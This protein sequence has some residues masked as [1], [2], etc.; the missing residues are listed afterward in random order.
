MPEALKI[1]LLG[2][3]MTA[4]EEN[5]I[6]VNE[7][8][9]DAKFFSEDDAP[10]DGYKWPKY[11]RTFMVCVDSFENGLARGS[12]HNYYYRGADEFRSLDQL[13]FLM[14]EVMESA[15]TPMRDSRFRKL[16]GKWKKREKRAVDDLYDCYPARIS[17]PYYT[18]DSI[19]IKKG[20]LA[21]FYIYPMY[22]SHASLQG[23]L[24]Q[25]GKGG[26]Q[27]LFRSEME[28]LF[29]LREALT[30]AENKE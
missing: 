5:R 12:L 29:L 30:T 14:E 18:P 27:I 16:E 11:T 13:L 2:K 26:K 23:V 4:M 19:Q 7:E 9:L 8:I 3:G 17:R 21:N 6:L 20:K 28:L 24:Q 15:E 25:A 10:R 22:R 1:K